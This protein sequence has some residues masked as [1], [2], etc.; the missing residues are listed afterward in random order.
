MD[1]SRRWW[2]QPRPATPPL[3]VRQPIEPSRKLFGEWVLTILQIEVVTIASRLR[4]TS[5]GCGLSIGVIQGFEK[6]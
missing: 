5:D 2:L 6:S 4:D 1:P 3:L